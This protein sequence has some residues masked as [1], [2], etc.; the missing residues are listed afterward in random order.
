VVLGIQADDLTGACDAGAPFAGRGL[1]T[2][3]V[4]QDDG[5]PSPWPRDLPAVVAIDTESRAAPAAVAAARARAAAVTLA[6]GRPRRLYKKLD[7]TLRG[8]LAAELAGML[9]GSGLASALVAPAFPAQGRVVRDDQVHVDGRL[10]DA[11]PIARDP[12]FPRTGAS[13]LAPLAEGGVRPLGALPLAT[14]R[15]GT[16][17]VAARLAGFAQLGGRAIAADAETDA[18]LATLAAAAAGLPVLLAGSAGLATA[19]AAGLAPARPAGAAPAAARPRRPLLVVAGS[20][21]PA[22]RAQ[23]ERLGARDDLEVLVPPPGVA[24]DPA[25]RPEAAARLGADARRR[26]ERRRPGTI[27]ATGG[28]TAVA[29]LRALGAWGLRLSGELEPGLAIGAL[30][31]GPFEGGLLVTKAGGFGDA[32]TLLRVWEAAA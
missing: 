22:T 13:V 27:V 24:D 7:S 23:L 2:V 11:G 20:A 31:G 30:A 28:E 12:G 10:L 25:R 14:V 4:V 29:L 6:G 21:H 9:E 16:E 18:D 5:P 1:A 19:M 3:V 32:D 15:R 26:V 8:R 17:A